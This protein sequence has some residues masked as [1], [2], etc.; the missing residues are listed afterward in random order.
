MPKPPAGPEPRPLIIAHRGASAHAPENTLAAFRRAVELG[1]DG[2]ELDVRLAGDGVAVVFHDPSLNRVAGR[3]GEIAGMNSDELRTVDAG[4][5]FNRRHPERADRSFADERIP[6][7]RETLQLLKRF[8]GLLYVELKG[9]GR[10]IEQL[11][12]AV[13][14]EIRD[15]PLLPRVVV[16]SFD[17]RALPH[18]RAALPGVRTAALF[19]PKFRTLLRKEKHILRLA[20]AA[21]A[22]EISLHYTLATRRLVSEAARG[23][24]D[25]VVWTVDRA[26]WARR[27][28]ELGLKAVITND[29]AKLIA[30]R[31]RLLERE[32][33]GRLTELSRKR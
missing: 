6:T 8:R 9:R 29:P 25:V 17:L 4:S 24:I 5:W 30:A 14:D 32:E 33:I 23:G 1:A 16:K 12:G 21:A 28:A 2:I 7:L 18:V 20:E 19:A 10:D 22:D 31:V 13:A 11:A 3:R 26:R 15:S 27:G